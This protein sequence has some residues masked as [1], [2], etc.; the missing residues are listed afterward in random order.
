MIFSTLARLESAGLVERIDDRFRLTELGKV[1]GELGIRVESVVRVGRALRGLPG[2]SITGRVL[3]AAAQ[4]TVELDE[5]LFPIHRRSV[6]ERQRWRGA[7]AGQGLPSSV[8]RE[9]AATED[10]AHTTRCKRLAAVTMWLDG[11]ELR[12]IEE[13]ILRHLPGENAAG[14]I[15]SS[16]ERTR[17]LIG[18]V[19]RIAN[20]VVGDGLPLAGDG[21]TLG[22]RLELGVPSSIAWLGKELGRRFDRGDYLALVR[23]GLVTPEALG[24]AESQVLARVMP[25][26]AK[27]SQLLGAVE[28]VLAQQGVALSDDAMPSQDGDV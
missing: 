5:I 26:E 11:I 9:L 4:I 10:A 21:D 12:R 24:A 3:V 6:Q 18:V 28:R 7:V 22:L 1:A 23:E 2:K 20:L 19:S 8:M 17:D 15:R 25:D 27:Q 16:A 14:P 13:S